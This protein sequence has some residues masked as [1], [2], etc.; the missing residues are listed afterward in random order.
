MVAACA[1]VKRFAPLCRARAAAFFDG[2]SQSTWLVCRM[3]G[4]AGDPRRPPEPPV[5][6]PH[7]TEPPA[8][9]PPLEQ[10]PVRDPPPRSPPREDPPPEDPPHD[11]PPPEEPPARTPHT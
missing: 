3:M 1:T 8:G 11:D 2:R 9:D 6:E 4:S 7:P 10:P 5:E